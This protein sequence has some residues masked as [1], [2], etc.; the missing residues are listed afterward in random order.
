M[1]RVFALAFGSL[2]A[3]FPADA[4]DRPPRI[5][6]D[7]YHAAEIYRNHQG[8]RPEDLRLAARYH[9]MAAEKGNAASA[10]K[11]AEMYENGAGVTQSYKNAL[12]WYR[13]SAEHGDKHAEFRLGFLHQKGLGTPVNLAAAISW[14]ERAARQDNEW[15]YHMLA[16]MYADG[17]G[18]RRDLK[19]ARALFEK[20]LPRTQDSWA[21]FKLASLIA[22]DDPAR[23]RRLLRQSAA[24]GNADAI[25]MLAERGW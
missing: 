1:R 20:S 25:K 14:Y 21:Q 2:F 16:F 6:W 8:A 7:W 9:R 18:V 17:E 24:A 10:Y 3:V 22:K 12:N 13:R 11:L 5:T 19:K 15:A 4:K 23:A